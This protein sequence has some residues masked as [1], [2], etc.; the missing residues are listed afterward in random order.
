MFGTDQG[1]NRSKGWTPWF[2]VRSYIRT[3]HV[4]RVKVVS[5]VSCQERRQDE[6]MMGVE[7]GL[8]SFLLGFASR[9]GCDGSKVGLPD[10]SL[11]T[12]L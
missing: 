12:P 6:D 7:V 11:G 9:Q 3:G 8:P 1:C 2:L 4:T 5:L 10:F